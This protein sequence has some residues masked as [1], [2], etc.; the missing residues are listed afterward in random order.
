VSYVPERSYD[1]EEVLPQ[2]IPEAEGILDGKRVININA[3]GEGQ[4]LV[5]GEGGDIANGDLI[6]TSSTAGKGMKQDDDIVRSKTVAKSR[7]NVTFTGP[8]EVKLIAC[9]YLCG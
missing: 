6:M 5:T 8:E 1:D 7:E 2:L 9:I 4:I 3:V